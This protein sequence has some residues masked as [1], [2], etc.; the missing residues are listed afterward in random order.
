ME[1][2]I[3]LDDIIWIEANAIWLYPII[4]EYIRAGRDLGMDYLSLGSLRYNEKYFVGYVYNKND[5]DLPIELVAYIQ[6][7]MI[8]SRLTLNYMETAKKYRGNG[9]ARRTID[10]F[11]NRVVTNTG[12]SVYVTTLSHDGKKANL[13]G[14]LQEKLDGDIVETS[15]RS[16][17]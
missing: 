8:P 7:K 12:I 3:N 17:V 9:I 11:V 1:E 5:S 4:Q 10:E 13:I 6:Y 14:K 16:T 2:K 15:K